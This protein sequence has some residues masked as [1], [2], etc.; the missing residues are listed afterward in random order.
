V[1]N[2]LGTEVDGSEAVSGPAHEVVDAIVATGGQAVADGGDASDWEGSQRIVDHALAAF[3]RLDIVV[4]NAGILRDRTI[5]SMT[6]DDWEAVLRVH[7]G[8][9]FCM[10]RWAARHWRERSKAGD[11]V[12]ARVINTTSNAGMYGNPGQANYTAAKAGVVGFT[13]TAAAEL[14]RYG[15]TVNAIAPGGRTRMT[16]ALFDDEMPAVV[17]GFDPF[18]PDNVAPLVV[19]LASSESRDVT[20]RV[21]E[22]WGGRIG[23][24]LSWRPGPRVDEPRRWDPA[25]VGP[26]VRQLLTQVPQPGSMLDA[27]R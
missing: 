13:I 6:H 1:V 14:A 24:P 16:E 11:D 8:A 2:D 12:D 3:G 7:L 15:V 5:V 25:Q 26:V 19:W 4:N 27:A 21:I 9:T 10:T 22:A 17:D 23:V 18:D 20:G